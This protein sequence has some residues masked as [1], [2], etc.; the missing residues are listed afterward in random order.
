MSN[1]TVGDF[2]LN[3][4]HRKELKKDVENADDQE[5]DYWYEQQNS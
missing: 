1:K 3:P 5:I 4:K 2:Q